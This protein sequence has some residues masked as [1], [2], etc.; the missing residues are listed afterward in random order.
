M[1][2]HNMFSRGGRKT[3]ESTT[4]DKLIVA[5]VNMIKEA[6]KLHKVNKKY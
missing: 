1:T 6:Y 5:S 2:I 3:Y 4:K